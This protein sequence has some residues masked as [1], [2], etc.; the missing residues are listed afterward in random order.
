VAFGEL[1]IGLQEEDHAWRLDRIMAMFANVPRARLILEH[2]ED[3]TGNGLPKFA[4]VKPAPEGVSLRSVEWHAII[5]RIVR[6]DPPFV[7]R[8][9][10]VARDR[11]EWEATVECQTTT[12]ETVRWLPEVPDERLE[13]TFLDHPNGAQLLA[14]TRGALLAHQEAGCPLFLERLVADTEHWDDVAPLGRKSHASNVASLIGNTC[15]GL[16]QAAFP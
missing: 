10:A 8:M 1:A 13:E 14:A 5:R 9:I 11:F 15:N 3:V 7:R 12:L 4:Q 2:V 6:R 16:Q